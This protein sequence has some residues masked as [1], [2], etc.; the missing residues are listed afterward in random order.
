M[1][2]VAKIQ[3][4]IMHIIRIKFFLIGRLIFFLNII[5]SI[6]ETVNLWYH[7]NRQSLE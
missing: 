5:E 1:K 6:L 2:N 7:S 3:A 4:T